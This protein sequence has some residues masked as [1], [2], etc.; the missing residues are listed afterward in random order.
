MRSKSAPLFVRKPSFCLRKES[1]HLYAFLT[2]DKLEESSQ[3]MM[4]ITVLEQNY[5]LK[6]SFGAILAHDLIHNAD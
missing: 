3:N 1:I 5:G 2:R 6:F 4:I